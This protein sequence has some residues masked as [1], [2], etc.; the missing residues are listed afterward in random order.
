M[1]ALGFYHDFLP[2]GQTPAS[3]DHG[4]WSDHGQTMVSA[5][6]PK[7]VTMVSDHGLTM[8]HGQYNKSSAGYLILNFL[9]VFTFW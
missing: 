4:A 2:Q 1:N 7:N 5:S 9:R 3:A 8:L 6:F